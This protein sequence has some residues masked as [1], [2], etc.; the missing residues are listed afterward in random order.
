MKER[1]Q[2]G[3]LTSRERG[4]LV[5]VV[6]CMN[7]TGTFILPLFIFPRKHM[8]AEIMDGSPPGSICL[9]SKRINADGHI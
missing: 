5:T 7:A 8:K 9:S 3:C 2:V 4:Q 1:R 6:V